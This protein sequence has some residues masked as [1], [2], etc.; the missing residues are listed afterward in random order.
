MPASQPCGQ[1]WRG[2]LI[3]TPG[4]QLILGHWG[5]MLVS[6][7]DR[8]DLISNWT[9]H[10]WRRVG[11]YITGNVYATV[12]GA[13]DPL[14]EVT[15]DLPAPLEVAEVRLLGSDAAVPHQRDGSALRI[16]LPAVLPASPAIT[17]RLSEGPG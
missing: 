10:L 14:T 7:V 16:H 15:I 9:P 13:H 6:F 5:E 11:E 12:L 17:F 1:S 2:R 4:L 8:A 3:G